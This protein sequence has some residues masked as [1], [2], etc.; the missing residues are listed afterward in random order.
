MTSVPEPSVV[1]PVWLLLG[2]K[3]TVPPVAPVLTASTSAPETN[4]I[5]FV[6][7]PAGGFTVTV[8][9]TRVALAATA[10]ITT[11]T[12]LQSILV[13]PLLKAKSQKLRAPL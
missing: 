13:P 9:A 11:P 4:A 10:P 5:A 8:A 1:P 6:T 12:L 7:V 3:C 2:F